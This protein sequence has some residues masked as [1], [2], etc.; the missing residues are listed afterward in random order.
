MVGFPMFEVS[1]RESAHNGRTW[2]RY[3]KELRDEIVEGVPP[4]DY[5]IGLRRSGG[6]DVW[7]PQGGQKVS[8]GLAGVDVQFDMSGLAAIRLESPAEGWEDLPREI[9][10]NTGV[11]SFEVG[12]YVLWGL[13]PG[14]VSLRTGGRTMTVELLAGET[15]VVQW[16]PQ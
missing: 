1:L 14:K 3:Y 16:S 7:S 10:T 8:V 15:K 11:H 6:K 12:P 2:R 9:R 4:G 13:A 5:E